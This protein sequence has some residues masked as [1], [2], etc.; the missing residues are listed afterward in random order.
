MLKKIPKLL[1]PELVKIMME[2][3]HGDEL[4]L[5]DAHF[6]AASHAQRLIRCDGH[7]IPQLLEAVLELYPLDGYVEA[8]V[9][10]MQVVEGDAVNPVIWDVYQNVLQQSGNPVQLEYV[11]R[12]AFYERAKR[13]YAIVAS[14]E[15]SQY[16]NLILKKG[17][18][19]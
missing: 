10:L 8:P 3:G 15:T 12:F 6:P 5:A 16:A 11:E 14:G 13:A 19:L 18:V 9:A 17:L 2:M 1:P 4:I 7:P